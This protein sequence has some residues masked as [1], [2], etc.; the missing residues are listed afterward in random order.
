MR[1]AV[2]ETRYIV[3]T[4]SRHFSSCM[5]ASLGDIADRVKDLG[6]IPCNTITNLLDSTVTAS[7]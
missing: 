2:T 1:N 4:I 3:K 5:G 6:C 7:A